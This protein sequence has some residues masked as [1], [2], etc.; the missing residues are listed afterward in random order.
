[1][2][3]HGPGDLEPAKHPNAPRQ[4]MS[5][6]RRCKPHD[7]WNHE[8]TKESDSNQGAR[9]GF[10]ASNERECQGRQQN[11][12]LNAYI[13]TDRVPN[14]CGIE[15]MVVRREQYSHHQAS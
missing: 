6:S 3:V 12:G 8:E 15:K 11:D 13:D 10:S 5:D 9:P 1:M 7:V 2:P 14:G 4:P